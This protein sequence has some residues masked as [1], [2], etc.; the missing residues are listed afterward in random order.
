MGGSRQPF[1]PLVKTRRGHVFLVHQTM[2]T[3]GPRLP[4]VHFLKHRLILIGFG[5]LHLR[6]CFD[7]RRQKKRC[8]GVRVW[9]S[10]NLLT[11]GA[12][13]P[14]RE[15]MGRGGDD[16]SNRW[17]TV[18]NRTVDVLLPIGGQLEKDDQI[19]ENNAVS[20]SP[21]REKNRSEASAWPRH[22]PEARR[23]S[24]RSATLRTDSRGP[25]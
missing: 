1:Q 3:P 6:R 9:G 5:N 16:W 19:H 4:K 23:C 25:P 24:T 15:P 11:C 13:V 8:S 17:S 14:V 20:T 18:P 22:I 2:T 7:S 12:V 21:S 10:R